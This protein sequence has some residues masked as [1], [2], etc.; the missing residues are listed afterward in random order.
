MSSSHINESGQASMVDVTDKLPTRRTALASARVFLPDEVLGCV[1][2]GDILTAKGAVFQ[3]ARIA[4][5]YA[6]KM[7][8]HLIPLCHP[9]PLDYCNVEIELSGSIA[10]IEAEVRTTAK[11]GVEMEALHAASTAALTIYDMCKSMGHG[12]VIS[13]IRLLKKTGGK[14]DYHAEG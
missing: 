10:V 14:L 11:T 3:L 5:V 13:E 1:K 6:S 8:G 12:I 9:L 7:T 2:G 4:G